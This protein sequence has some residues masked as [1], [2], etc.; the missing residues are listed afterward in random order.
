MYFIL[1][2]RSRLSSEPEAPNSN[3]GSAI[4]TVVEFTVVVVPL[5][6]KS[7]VT[8]KLSLTVVSEVVC[9]IEI[10]TPEFAVPIAIPPVVSE[11][12]MSISSLASISKVVALISTAP[13]TVN[14]PS[15]SVLSKFVTPSISILPDISNVA[16]ASS[17]VKV[18]FLKLPTSLFP[19]T[20]TALLTTTVPATEPSNRLSSAAVEVIPS[21]VF[22]SAA[23]AVINV[24]E[25]DVP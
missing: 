7:P 14:D 21:K 1:I 23:V 5:T 19:S 15:I 3:I 16:A 22:N 13:S 24:S 11:V 18:T 4:L 2:P 17:P 20:T 12:S 9:P 6:V 10:G 8:V 25:P